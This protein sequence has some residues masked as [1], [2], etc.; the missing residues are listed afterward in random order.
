MKNAF[1]PFQRVLKFFT[2]PELDKQPSPMST[3]KLKAKL[4]EA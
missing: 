1:R 4:T 2:L 3:Q